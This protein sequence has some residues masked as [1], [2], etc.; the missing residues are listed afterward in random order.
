MSAPGSRTDYD[1]LKA[2]AFS[3]RLL[4]ALNHG[5]LC[6][7][8]SVGHRTGLFDVMSAAPPATSAELASR[9][10][11]HERYVPEWLGA[12][13]TGRVVDVDPTTGTS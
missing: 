5:A 10:G 13:V 4:E 8:M 7:M 2:E 3:G 6:L 1:P 9:A 12:M 11:L